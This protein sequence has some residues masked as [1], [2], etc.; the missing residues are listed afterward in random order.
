MSLGTYFANAWG[1]HS[2]KAGVQFGRIGNN[3]DQGEQKDLVTLGWGTF[4][5]GL[6]GSAAGKDFAGTYGYYSYR[7]FKRLGDIHSNN[8]ALFLQD[9]WE[10][11]KKLTLITGLSNDPAAVGNGGDGIHA[12]GTGCF[13]TNE[14]LQMGG[15]GAGISADQLIAKAVGSKYCI[16]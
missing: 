6:T 9:S 7:Q 4:W 14:V 12:R 16:T 10:I 3:V 15:F 8:V 13:L 5:T 2:L 11:K 1:H